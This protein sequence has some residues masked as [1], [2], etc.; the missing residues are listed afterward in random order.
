MTIFLYSLKRSFRR[1]LNIILICV[2]PLGLL[3]IPRFG[4][5]EMPFGFHLYGELVFFLAFSLI[6][7]VAEDRS[8]GIL[9]RIAAAPVTHFSYLSQTLL[10]Y[11]CLLL[12]Q[13]AAMVLGGF[14]L[15]GDV[16]DKPLR[17]LASYGTF[18]LTA[19]AFCLAICSL[20]RLRE[21]AYSSCNI[22]IIFFAAIGGSMVPTSMMPPFLKR[23]A[24]VSPIYWLHN[25]MRDVPGEG[26]QFALSLAVM[27]LFALVF[28][29]AGS[30][31][32]M[33]S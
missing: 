21:I 29:L 7:A 13:N 18:S 23:F 6:S 25:A 24:M 30:K 14:L 28:L 10:A 17:M 3:F 27:L 20:I 1:P 8:S 31:R 5:W 32:R 33:V 26:D 15:H 22:L 16:L 9:T 11:A 2:L 19:L 12:V 4:D